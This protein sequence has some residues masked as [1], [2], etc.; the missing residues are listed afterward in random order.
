MVLK[1]ASDAFGARGYAATRLIDI[2][3]EVGI[4][5]PALYRH[6][7]T[8]YDLFAAAVDRLS[9]DVS[10]AVAEVTACDDPRDELRAVLAAFTETFLDHRVS[11]NLYRWEQRV[12]REP[13]RVRT[14]EA[15]I[16]LHRRLRSLIEAARPGLVR[17][18]ADLLTVAALSV[19]A[20]PATHRVTMPRRAATDLVAGAAMTL[21]DVD[22]PAPT[23]T[24]AESPG[25]VPAGRR[26]SILAAAVALFAH[27][28]FHEVTVEDIGAAVGLPAS[29]VYRHFSSKSAILTAS[30][31]RTADRTTDAVASALARAQ[32]P[33]QALFSLASSYSTL[34]VDDPDI[35]SVYLSGTG[36]LPDDELRA[37]RRQQRTTVDE[38][39]TWVVRAR[40]DLTAPAA[41]FLVHASLNLAGDLVIGR[42]DVDAPTVAAASAAVLLG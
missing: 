7:P 13:D 11:G 35:M 32:T 3:D 30:L 10:T 8:K 22:L 20:S 15:R 26:E 37:L 9:E 1:T 21:L 24:P 31:W 23:P 42:P 12:L 16:G 39:A 41:R 34:C 19:A 17:P 38:W 27:E 28:G 18:S 5:A 25:L 4:S 29:G 33:E 36:S 40:P 6:F 2:A 14:R